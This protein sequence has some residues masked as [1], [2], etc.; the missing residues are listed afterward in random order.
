M[1]GG[2]YS[3]P[4]PAYEQRQGYGGGESSRTS[5][6]GYRSGER[7]AQSESWRRGPGQ[8]GAA[9]ERDAGHEPYASRA[10]G[11]DVGRGTHAQA[12]NRE[13]QRAGRPNGPGGDLR[14]GHSRLGGHDF[15]NR[16]DGDRSHLAARGADRAGG[17]ADLVHGDRGGGF[18]GKGD[19]RAALA[20]ARRLPSAHQRPSR[21]SSGH[22]FALNGH[23]N[24]SFSAAPYAW[25][26]G[27]GYS[28]IG[29]GGYLAPDF[30][31]PD[32]FVVDYDL[33]GVPAPEPDFAWIRYGPDLL[34][35]QLDTGEIIQVISGVFVDWSGSPYY[36]EVPPAFRS[37]P[38]YDGDPDE[39]PGDPP[40]PGGAD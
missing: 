15:A 6:F 11:R 3:R 14:D 13:P 29:V 1:N 25:P 16:T 2:G 20:Q 27:R 17:R 21:S 32:Y 31:S 40:P 9:S 23:S 33:Y 5:Q 30:W 4:S 12:D 8:T 35:M 34:L 37:S 36:A 39:M 18:R 24:R 10:G 28:P 22:G 19:A 7:G 38:T 26:R